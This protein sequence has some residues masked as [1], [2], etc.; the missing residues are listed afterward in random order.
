MIALKCTGGTG[1]DFY[2]MKYEV[3]V[4]F[5]Y[6][7]GFK[8]TEESPIRKRPKVVSELDPP[9]DPVEVEAEIERAREL[10][11]NLT[12]VNNGFW[13]LIN[14]ESV[15]GYFTYSHKF[16]RGYGGNLGS[17]HT[18]NF[19]DKKKGYKNSKNYVF[20]MGDTVWTQ[21]PAI[22][23]NRGDPSKSL[24]TSTI[25]G[26][27]DPSSD[28][29]NS[30]PCKVEDIKTYNYLHRE[31]RNIQKYKKELQESRNQF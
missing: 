31:I 3:P 16:L 24:I 11:T 12:L 1:G 19:Q 2:S 6:E 8:V 10:R 13:V 23:I 20:K 5:V 7:D 27:F 21:E 29:Q 28:Y 26:T 15:E 30:T 4:G 18:V 9:R 17:P 25:D 14:T 22:V